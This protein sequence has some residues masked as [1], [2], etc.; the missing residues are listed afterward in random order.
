MDEDKV[1]MHDLLVKMGRNIVFR[2]CPNDP[3]KRSR[4]CHYEDI[5]KVL[6]RNKVKG[7]FIENLSSFPIFLFNKFEI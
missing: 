7:F 6:K 2:E 1:W 5:D 4:L 3:G